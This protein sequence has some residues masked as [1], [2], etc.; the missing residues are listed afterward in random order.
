MPSSVPPF[1]RKS[2]SAFWSSPPQPVLFAPVPMTTANRTRSGRSR[3]SSCA[4]N[5]PIDRPTSATGGSQT[6]SIS[7]AV[8]SA[9][10]RNVHGTG[11]SHVAAPI[12]RL[13]NV[14]LRKAPWKYG[15]W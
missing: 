8:S 1:A 10:P 7:S 13:S 4:I 12:P 14:V 9:N 5:E 15:T 3:Q 11:A 2:I 6:A